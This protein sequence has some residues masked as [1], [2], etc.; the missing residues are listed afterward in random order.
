MDHTTPKRVADLHRQGDRFDRLMGEQDERTSLFWGRQ[1]ER[2]TLPLG[3]AVFVLREDQKD[4]TVWHISAGMW[5]S[6]P[7]NAHQHL[8]YRDASAWCNALEKLG[9]RYRVVARLIRGRSDV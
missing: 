2:R 7:E 8:S 4:R 3:R 6:D 9:F 5:S 1:R